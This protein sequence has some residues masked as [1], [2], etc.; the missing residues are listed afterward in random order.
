MSLNRKTKLLSS[1]KQNIPISAQNGPFEGQKCTLF[2]MEKT[3]LVF[4]T[5]S[6]LLRKNHTAWDIKKMK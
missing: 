5:V 4:S 6:N 3:I 2:G 1:Y